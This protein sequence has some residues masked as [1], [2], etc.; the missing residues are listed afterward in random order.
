MTSVNMS[1]P[2]NASARLALSEREL[3]LPISAATWRFRANQA[4]PGPGA[5]I[6]TVP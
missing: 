2:D 6:I 5:V 4:V 1:S 3:A